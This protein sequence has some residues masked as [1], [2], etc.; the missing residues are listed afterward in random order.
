M[1]YTKNETELETR[2][3]EYIVANPRSLQLDTKSFIEV[4]TNGGT[5]QISIEDSER[6]ERIQ[7][8]L[9]EHI[10]SFL[11]DIYDMKNFTLDFSLF[12]KSY[13][14]SSFSKDWVQD[15]FWNRRFLNLD[16]IILKRLE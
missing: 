2:L 9:E 14:L 5:Y 4:Y 13:L 8:K 12:T 11:S 15:P 16:P 10:R 1:A 7:E 6:A 3:S